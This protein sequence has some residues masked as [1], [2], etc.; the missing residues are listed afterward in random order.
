MTQPFTLIDEGR[1][2]SVEAEVTDG[3]VRLS[4]STVQEQL[5]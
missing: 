2:L 1:V 5:G 3:R 4:A